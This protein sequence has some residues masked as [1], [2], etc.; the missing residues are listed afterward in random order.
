PR[1]WSPP[2][3]SQCARPAAAG[4]AG[5]C[6]LPRAQRLAPLNPADRA[7]EQPDVCRVLFSR[8]CLWRGKVVTQGVMGLKRKSQRNQPQPAR[9]LTWEAFAEFIAGLRALRRPGAPQQSSDA[10]V[11]A[12]G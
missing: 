3:L 2:G 11:A 10:R 6:S 1:A 9:M 12:S 7:A 4:S 5:S 8:G